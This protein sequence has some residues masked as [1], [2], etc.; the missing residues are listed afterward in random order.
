M[1]FDELAGGC[2]SAGTIGVLRGIS[3][4]RQLTLFRAVV[5]R[6]ARRSVRLDPLPGLDQAWQLLVAAQSRDAAAVAPV[7]FGPQAGL[8]AATALRRLSE[9]SSGD[10]V[11]LWV[12]LGYL[13]LTAVA[14]AIRAGV[15]FRARVPVRDGAVVLPTL[16]LARLPGGRR[17]EIAEVHHSAGNRVWVRGPAGTVRLPD[18]PTADGRGWL[19]TRRLR[20]DGVELWL[21]DLDPYRGFT[22]PLPPE[23]I[24]DEDAAAWADRLTAAW[25]L[26][27]HQFPA[28]AAEIRAGLSTLVPTPA[29]SRFTTFSASTA[30]AFGCVVLS[31]PPDPVTFAVTLVHEFNHSKL[32]ALLELVELHGPDRGD[33]FYAPWRDDPRPLSGLLHGVYSFLGVTGFWRRHRHAA[34]GAG[35]HWAEFEFAHW[36]EQTARAAR[37]LAGARGLTAL[38]RRFTGVMERQLESWCEE[39]VPAELVEIARRANLD[40]YATWRLR[41]LRADPGHVRDLAVAWLAGRPRAV[42]ATPEPEPVL[43]E[44]STPHLQSA[45]RATLIR[46]RLTEAGF[47]AELL[48]APELAITE[49]PGTTVA[50]LAFVD[51][52]LPAAIAGYRDQLAGAP[53]APGAWIGLGL[54]AAQETLLTRPEL[55][56][57]LHR[58]LTDRRGAQPD[59]LRLAE[60]LGAVR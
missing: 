59:P 55:V 5:D 39:P 51:G 46:L 37:T 25:G 34:G 29:T 4:S 60:W 24:P 9:A 10:P 6:A 57:A 23:R 21:D 20:A 45:A 3:R 13:H 18:D 26:L 15:P 43:A 35:K 42:V 58:E 7:L 14:S 48:H 28:A 19:A 47:F 16:G 49:I 11:P 53:A 36:R 38:G 50:D 41:H 30:D 2:A 52:D 40:H 8:W 32:S 17:W 44:D 22:E 27:S 54:A 33:R 1:S 12:D 31:L 56:V